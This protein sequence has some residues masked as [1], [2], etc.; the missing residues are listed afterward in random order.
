MKQQKKLMSAEEVKSL[1]LEI[2]DDITEFCK[3]K[4]LRYYLAYGTLI[5]A[6]RHNGFIPWDDD[7]DIMM[8]RPDYEI[9]CKEY[10]GR[11]PN[12]KVICLENDKDCFINFAKV[13][14]TTTRYQ[15]DY[16]IETSYGVFVD[17]F[18]LDGYMNILQR[19]ICRYL[20]YVIHYKSLCCSKDNSVAKNIAIEAIK[21]VLA[22]VP[23]RYATR[24]LVRVSQLRDYDK[25]EYVYY[26]SDKIKPLKRTFFEKAIFHQFENKK[27]CVPS[28]YDD[29]LRL[30]YGDYMKLP[31][32]EERINKH[33]A[34][35]W[36][37][38]Q[39]TSH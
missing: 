4:K 32:E 23:M 10:S 21:G 19:K 15:E 22:P 8:P 38:G 30:Q 9:L 16:A 2:L 26:F 27:Y 20:Y 17:I 34:T 18:P 29:V 6:I 11:N 14:D 12:F 5:G 25:S 35:A 31:P 3:K 37:E 7:I 1:Q 33:K 24:L 28:M 13:H 36:R 39:G